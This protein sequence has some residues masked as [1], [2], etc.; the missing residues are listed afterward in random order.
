MNFGQMNT[1]TKRLKEILSTKQSSHIKSVH[2]ASLMTD[3]EGSFQIPLFG[4]ERIQV[5]EKQN[6]Q[7]IQLYR[8]V[9]EAR[10][11]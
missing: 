10:E 8:T 5:F 9:S 2:L 7:V 6:P 4:K 1:Y 3:L 11:F